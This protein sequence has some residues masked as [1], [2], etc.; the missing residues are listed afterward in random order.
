MSRNFATK[1]GWT[2]PEVAATAF[3]AIKAPMLPPDT[4]KG[5][6]AFITGGGTG[7]GNAEE[8]QIHS[9]IQSFI[10]SFIH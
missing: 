2:S 8:V 6:I 9:F 4:F 5:K 10:D 3:P 7:L 1:G